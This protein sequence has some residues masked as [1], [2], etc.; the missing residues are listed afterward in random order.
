MSSQ[1]LALLII[2]VAVAAILTQFQVGSPR[3]ST[4]ISLGHLQAR[5]VYLGFFLG[6]SNR[7]IYHLLKPE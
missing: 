6:S 1:L 3:G 2:H 7:N 5:T 4:W